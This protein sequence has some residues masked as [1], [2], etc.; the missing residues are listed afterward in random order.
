MIHN[1]PLKGFNINHKKALTLIIKHIEEILKI[2]S[3]FHQFVFT[4]TFQCF[5]GVNVVG[6]NGRQ[7]AD[8]K[9]YDPEPGE[10][11]LF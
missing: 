9:K 6:N 11:C 8:Q 1:V 5:A 2:K 7:C 10:V 3:R 4:Q